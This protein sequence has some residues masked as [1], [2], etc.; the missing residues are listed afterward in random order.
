MTNVKFTDVCTGFMVVCT[1]GLATIKASADRLLNASC[2][3]KF[4]VI[5][6]SDIG[7]HSSCAGY[8]FF[9]NGLSKCEMYM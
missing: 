5:I 7:L 6:Q 3:A 9:W 4:R 2:E 1:S 8:V